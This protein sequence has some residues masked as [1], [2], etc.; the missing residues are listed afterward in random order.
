MTSIKVI[1]DRKFVSFLEKNQ[2]KGVDLCDATKLSDDEEI[3]REVA[4]VNLLFIV[5]NEIIADEIS[6]IADSIKVDLVLV[7]L[8][9]KFERH[10]RRYIFEQAHSTTAIPYSSNQ[11]EICYKIIKAIADSVNNGKIEFEA[12]LNFFY[13]SKY[14]EYQFGD[15]NNS[16]I[17]WVG[18]DLQ[19]RDVCFS[20]F[21]FH[22]YEVLNLK[23]VSTGKKHFTG[24]INKCIAYDDVNDL[25]TGSDMK[26]A[27][28]GG[29]DFLFLIVEP[30]NQNL[31]KYKKLIRIARNYGGCYPHVITISLSKDDSIGMIGADVN[32]R[33]NDLQSFYEDFIYRFDRRLKFD[34]DNINMLRKYKRVRIEYFNFEL[35]GDNARLQEFVQSFKARKFFVHV[36]FDYLNYDFD[37]EK[38]DK[39]EGKI[40]KQIDEMIDYKKLCRKSYYYGTG[41]SIFA[42]EDKVLVAFYIKG[43]TEYL[44]KEH[45]G[46]Y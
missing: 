26:R 4:G 34:F 16:R 12:V 13:G 9:E 46:N 22:L 32:I 6:R 37:H 45:Y 8:R 44:T 15:V 7:I 10:A 27:I 25:K 42:L 36:W 14:F 19:L 43:M 30:D 3:V 40:L 24:K 17:N 2:I 28:K 21:R 5:T 41:R 31:W 35:E 23:V 18:E 1:T 20:T 39:E 33:T 29:I 11:N 38:Y